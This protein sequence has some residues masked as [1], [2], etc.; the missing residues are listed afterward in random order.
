M[1]S[2]FGR[3]AAMVMSSP[4]M[5]KSSSNGLVRARMVGALRRGR[6][7]LVRDVGN[8]GGHIRDGGGGRKAGGVMRWEEGG[9]WRMVYD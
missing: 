2:S 6:R 3:W 9:R 7:R 1:I 5:I 4:E 8:L